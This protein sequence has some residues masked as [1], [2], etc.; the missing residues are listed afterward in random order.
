MSKEHRRRGVVLALGAILVLAAGVPTN[1]API[2]FD[3]PSHGEDGHFHWAVP[4]GDN[5][6]WLDLM[7]P[8]DA[9]PGTPWGDSSL[10]HYFDSAT[11]W[12]TIGT[13]GAGTV[14]VEIESFWIA[15]LAFGA[16][17]PSGA[18]TSDQGYVYYEGYETPWPAD[19]AA[20]VGVH[21]HI[22]AGT[23]YGWIGCLRTGEQVEAFAWGYETEPCVP[24]AAGVPEPASLA[25]LGLGAVVL[26]GC[27]RRRPAES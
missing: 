12:G 21:F 14:Q 2:R 13:S 5:T 24:I 9:Q 19:E 3:N 4:E 27:R 11:P 26:A 15:P 6:N 10:Q 25:V 18:P 16:M 17:I 23:Q 1:A 22:G 8:A 20:Y 7:Q